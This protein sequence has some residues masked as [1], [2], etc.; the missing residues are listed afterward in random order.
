MCGLPLARQRVD[1]TRLK[2][3]ARHAFIK[4]GRAARV[5]A[6]D[7]LPWATL[8]QQ[9]VVRGHQRRLCKPALRRLAAQHIAQRHQ[10]HALVVGHV[11]LHHA[12]F[13]KVRLARGGKVNC[14]HE[15]ILAPA[16]QQL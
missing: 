7:D 14:V 11:V 9:C 8:V 2:S 15:S 1:T 4:R 5:G 10:R 3:A 6:A 13:L 16:A 12:E